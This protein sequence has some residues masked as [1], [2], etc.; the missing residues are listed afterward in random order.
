MSLSHFIFS[1]SLPMIFLCFFFPIKIV[2]DSKALENKLEFNFVEL[3]S[4]SLLFMPIS[5]F[6]SLSLSINAWAKYWRTNWI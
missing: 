2:V 3:V 1:L 4:S 6:I 5:L